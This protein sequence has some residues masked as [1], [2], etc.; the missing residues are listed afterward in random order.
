VTEAD[1]KEKSLS[2]FTN[3]LAVDADFRPRDPL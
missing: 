3:A 1:E 2:D